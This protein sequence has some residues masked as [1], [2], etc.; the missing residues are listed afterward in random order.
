MP[1]VIVTP[2]VEL[3]DVALMPLAVNRPVLFKVILRLPLSPGSITPLPLPL[4][5]VFEIDEISRNAFPTTGT[6]NDCKAA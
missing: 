4:F 1:L 2:E 5:S 6:P 3:V